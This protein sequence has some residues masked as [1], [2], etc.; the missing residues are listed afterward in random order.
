MLPRRFTHHRPGSLAEALSLLAQYGDDA[1]LI[2]GGTE[3][4][5]ALKARVLHYQHLIDIKQLAELKGVRRTGDAIVIGALTTHFE[6][7]SDRIVAEYLPGYA[8]LSDNVAN[9]RVR[10]AGTLGGNL[11]F[12]EPHADPPAMLAA[13][14]A[15]LT[16]AGP[17]STRRVDVGDFIQSEF[18]TC[19]EADEI[20]TEIAVPAS[21]A[22]GSF[23]YEK[24]GHLER[25]A[26]GIAAGFIGEAASGQWRLW[27]GAISGRPVR[28]A[29][30]EGELQAATLDGIADILPRASTAAA[31]ALEASDDLHG[32]ADYKRHLAGVLIRRTVGRAADAARDRLQ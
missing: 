20:L 1:T 17:G 32:G 30:L 19:R 6:L 22:R 26:V 14:G 21:A 29:S 4:V 5:I 18:V 15:K 12:A 7:A 28:L 23:F 13:L 11:S 2:A 16:L 25:P 9:I 24:C 8:A 3:L 31:E 10:V 27:A